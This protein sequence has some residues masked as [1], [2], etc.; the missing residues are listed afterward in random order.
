M[1]FEIKNTKMK[2]KLKNTE[3]ISKLLNDRFEIGYS[4]VKIILEKNK[5]D[6]LIDEKQFEKI[7]NEDVLLKIKY[8]T[9]KKCLQQII[10]GLLLIVIGLISTF[11]FRYL[12][13]VGGIILFISS[14]FGIMS[15]K[16]TKEQKEYLKN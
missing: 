8:R 15:N 16:L 14:F 7:H 12:I 3:D 1:T 5:I 4:Q 9:Y 11:S 10:V 13:S 2:N 6:G